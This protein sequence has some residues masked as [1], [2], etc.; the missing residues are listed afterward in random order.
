VW[1]ITIFIL[2][3]SEIYRDMIE[4][5]ILP[6]ARQQH[7]LW[8]ESVAYWLLKRY[9]LSLKALVAS[10][11][12]DSDTLP[13]AEPPAIAK[14]SGSLSLRPPSATTTTTT[15]TTTSTPLRSSTSS[16]TSSTST[17]ENNKQK[18]E[19]RNAFNPAVVHFLKFLQKKPVVRHVPPPSNEAILGLLRRAVYAYLHAGCPILALEQ[20]IA[21]KELMVCIQTNCSLLA[22]I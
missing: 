20:T 14:V 19:N 12:E 8:L 13:T 21:C 6:L 4:S 16:T 10:T 7:D 9:E 22:C 11:E 2:V 17:A 3:C 1:T 5:H 18:L 15:T